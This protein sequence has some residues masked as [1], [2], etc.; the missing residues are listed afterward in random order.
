M[1][2]YNTDWLIQQPVQTIEQIRDEAK[3]LIDILDGQSPDIYS[4]VGKSAC[5]GVPLCRADHYCCRPCVVRDP[6]DSSLL[7]KLAD[8]ECLYEWLGAHGVRHSHPFYGN[9][10]ADHNGKY[11]RINGE[12][13][14][15]PDMPVLRRNNVERHCAPFE[16]Q[17]GP[18]FYEYSDTESDQDIDEE[19]LREIMLDISAQG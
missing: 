13:V 6:W 19:Y 18:I 2:N 4:Q 1:E 5:Q 9:F 10:C 3:D 7:P 8:A 15:V 12:W 14:Q 16:E 11:S 17:E